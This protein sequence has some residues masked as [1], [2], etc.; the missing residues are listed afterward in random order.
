MEY[1]EPEDPVRSDVAD[2]T[3]CSWGAVD[4]GIII[5][6]TRLKARIVLILISW[7]L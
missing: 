6:K 4:V 2:R 7:W 5:Y 1:G 3:L